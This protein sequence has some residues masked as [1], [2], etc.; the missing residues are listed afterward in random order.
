MKCGIFGH[1][2]DNCAIFG[3]RGEVLDKVAEGGC[4]PPT[5][6]TPETSMDS[7]HL[8]PTHSICSNSLDPPRALESTG[9]PLLGG[10]WL[11]FAKSKIDPKI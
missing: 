4:P 8:P 1:L 2:Q 6:L 3:K 5:V 11:R 9:K 7:P 10:P